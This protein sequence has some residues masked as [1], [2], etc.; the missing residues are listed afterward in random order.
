MF[1]S[2]VV[3]ST[4]PC[5]TEYPMS[6]ICKF[7]SWQHLAYYMPFHKQLTTHAA[8]AAIKIRYGFYMYT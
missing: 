1:Y 2:G 4:T 5:Q 3:Q 7:R 6:H 8:D